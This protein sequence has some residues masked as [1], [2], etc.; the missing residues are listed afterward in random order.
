MRTISL[1]EINCGDPTSNLSA[2]MKTYATNSPPSETSVLKQFTIICES[3]FLFSDLSVLNPST[4]TTS[5]VWSP[6][7]AYNGTQFLLLLYTLL[8]WNWFHLKD[9]MPIKSNIWIFGLFQNFWMIFEL[10]L[11]W[12]FYSK[13]YYKIDPVDSWRINRFISKF[14]YYRFIVGLMLCDQKI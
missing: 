9:L 1:K 14:Q 6:T 4:C 7:P 11:Y 8:D 5:G 10:L 12:Q 13:L 3:G 2:Q